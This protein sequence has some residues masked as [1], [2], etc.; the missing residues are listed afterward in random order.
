MARRNRVA[1]NGPA[2]ALTVNRDTVCKDVTGSASAGPGWKA[3]MTGAAV[4]LSGDRWH[5]FRSIF[6]ALKAIPP[7]V[8]VTLLSPT[9]KTMALP[10]PLMVMLAAPTEDRT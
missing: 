10:P 4:A 2:I 5:Q 1:V 6:G 9:F 8:S 7:A 3:A